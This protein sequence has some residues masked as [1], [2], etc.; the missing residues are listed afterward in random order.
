MMNRTLDENPINTINYKDESQ[1]LIYYAS[2]A[3]SDLIVIGEKHGSVLRRWIL[4]ED[5][6]ERVMDF[7]NLPVLIL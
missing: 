5:I 7:S 2:K 6:V 1:G 3:K 4:G